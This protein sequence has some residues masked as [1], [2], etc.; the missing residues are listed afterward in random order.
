M[1]RPNLKISKLSWLSGY[2]LLSLLSVS[3]QALP[4]TAVISWSS[5]E[6]ADGYRVY[7][8]VDGEKILLAETLEL[9][10]TEKFDEPTV[11]G[12]SAFNEYGESEIIPRAVFPKNLDPEMVK[13]QVEIIVKGKIFIMENGQLIEKPVEVE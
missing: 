8:F 10:H 2:L 9:T 11:F 4:D 3:S 12:V 6:R 1:T 13:Y 7:K 5:S